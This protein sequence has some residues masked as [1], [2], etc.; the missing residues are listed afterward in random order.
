MVLVMVIVGPM[1]GNNKSVVAIFSTSIML[2]GEMNVMYLFVRYRF[3]WNEVDYSLYST[4][5]VIAHMCGNY[6]KHKHKPPVKS[7][8]KLLSGTMFSLMFFSKF[9]K[10][11]DAILGMISCSSKIVSSLLYAFAPSPI[12]FYAGE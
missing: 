9:L 11:D 10:C 7:D 5:H 4:F 2:S 8:Q 1:H 6:S 3:G 12:I